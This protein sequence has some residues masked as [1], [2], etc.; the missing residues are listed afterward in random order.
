M[1]LMDKI[2]K[3]GSEIAEAIEENRR[4]AAMHD[5]RNSGGAYIALGFFAML[6]ACVGIIPIIFDSSQEAHQ[7]VFYAVSVWLGLLVLAFVSV[8]KSRR[9][10]LQLARRG[11]SATAKVTR[12]LVIETE[13]DVTKYAFRC[14]FMAK[15]GNGE[16]VEVEAQTVP[17]FDDDRNEGD[18]IHVLY[19][20]EDP[21]TCAEMSGEREW[22]SLFSC[23]YDLLFAAMG[24]AFAGIIAWGLRHSLKTTVM[25]GKASSSEIDW[26]G[27]LTR[28]Y[29]EIL[30]HAPGQR[31]LELLLVALGAVALLGAMGLLL[32]GLS[33]WLTTRGK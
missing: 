13:D 16:I 15:K 9:Q 17:G 4:V 24:I 21:K 33:T 28:F 1:N 7:A 11:E 26:I 30:S 2:K 20:P 23:R 14:L 27:M 22:A 5:L 32:R 19:L 25:L 12:R 3:A 6:S 18:E 29:H 8:R 10:L 31:N